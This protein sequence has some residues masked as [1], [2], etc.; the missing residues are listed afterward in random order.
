MHVGRSVFLL[1]VAHASVNAPFA[2]LGEPAVSAVMPSLQVQ[3]AWEAC[4]VM[5][6]VAGLLVFGLGRGL[7][8]A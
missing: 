4:L 1:A 8:R 6:G 7:Y 5:F 3:P 2:W